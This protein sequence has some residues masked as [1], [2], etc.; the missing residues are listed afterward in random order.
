[1]IPASMGCTSAVV[2]LGN[3]TTVTLL[4]RYTSIPC[5]RAGRALSTLWHDAL[6]IVSTTFLFLNLIR[7]LKSRSKLLKILPVIQAAPLCSHFTQCLGSSFLKQWCC[8]AFPMTNG[9]SRWYPS[10]EQQN[11]KVNR[12]MSFFLPLN[13]LNAK[14][15]SG[16]AHGYMP[17]SSML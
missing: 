15:R 14:V 13:G 7:L 9:S 11:M 4:K 8:L 5:M 1:M 2:F 10:A 12:F 6:S 3:M 16:A 17:V